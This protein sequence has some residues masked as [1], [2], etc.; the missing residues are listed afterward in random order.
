[1]NYFWRENHTQSSPV[2]ERYFL[3]YLRKLGFHI[4]NSSLKKKS[5]SSLNAFQNKLSFSFSKS[6]TSPPCFHKTRAL[7]TINL[8]KLCIVLAMKAADHR[9]KKR[10]G[11]F[12]EKA[13]PKPMKTTRWTTTGLETTANITGRWWVCL[14]N[15]RT[16]NVLLKAHW[17]FSNRDVWLWKDSRRGMDLMFVL[18]T[19]P[20]FFARETVIIVNLR[21]DW[22]S[23][24]HYFPCP[25]LIKL[26]ASKNAEETNKKKTPQIS[27]K[28]F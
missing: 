9:V 6:W 14:T 25:Q 13:V 19:L 12:G 18:L 1:M 4:K 16:L 21:Q 5:S 7:S 27:E 24:I 22:F 11:K 26:N 15:Y 2:L 10:G 17:L 23:S 3:G 8:S 20:A 28:G